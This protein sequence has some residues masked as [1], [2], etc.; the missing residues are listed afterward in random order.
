MDLFTC[1]LSLYNDLMSMCHNL[2]QKICLIFSKKLRDLYLNFLLSSLYV[3]I[4]AGHFFPNFS[5]LT[6]KNWKKYLILIKEIIIPTKDIFRDIQWIIFHFPVFEMHCSC[7][8]IKLLFFQ[9]VKEK[10]TLLPTI[11]N[12]DLMKLAGNQWYSSNRNVFLM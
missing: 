9:L 8:V 5:Q 12:L 1:F 2:Q 11:R 7:M 4:I 10:S 3:Y 6:S